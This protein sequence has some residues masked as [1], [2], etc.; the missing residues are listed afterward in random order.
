MTE[1]LHF[2]FSRSCIGEGN[3]HPLQC[4][5][6]ENPRDGGAWR[7]A[8]YGVTQSRTRLKRLS[9][10][11]MLSRLVVSDALRPHGLQPAENLCP[12]DS[13]GQILEWAAIALL[14]GI[15]PTQGLN[16]ALLRL[17][18]WQVGSSPPAGSLPLQRLSH[19]CRSAQLS[20]E[21]PYCFPEQLYQ[22]TFP[23]T[24]HKGFMFS[25]SF[26]MLVLGRF[27]W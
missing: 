16:P 20:E 5:C 8:I 3:G 19:Q 18:R 11:S 4:S 10:S 22:F 7:A 2:R 9:S 15:F 24:L 1:R 23:L 27:F 21:A 26:P 17:L 13:P 6:L 14:Q 25:T 12:G